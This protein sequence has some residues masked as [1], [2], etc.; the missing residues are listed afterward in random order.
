MPTRS[1]VDASSWRPT[2]SQSHTE[3]EAATIAASMQARTRRDRGR[4]SGWRSAATPNVTIASRYRESP[5]PVD[6]GPN[7]P[8]KVANQTRAPTA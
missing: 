6:E 7:S 2:A 3:I 5:S 8:L 4:S 1:P